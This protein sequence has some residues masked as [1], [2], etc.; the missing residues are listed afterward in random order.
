[1]SFGLK[2]VKGW[3]PTN[4]YYIEDFFNNSFKIADKFNSIFYP[5]N[6]YDPLLYPDPLKFDFKMQFKIKNS[7][8]SY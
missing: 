5:K 2:T 8:I 1:M 6:G 4:L 7:K 3:C